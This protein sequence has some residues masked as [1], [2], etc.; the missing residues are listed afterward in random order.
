MNFTDSRFTNNATSTVLTILA[1]ILG[2][3]GGLLGCLV[4]LGLLGL[5]SPKHV[6][7]KIKP[8][9]NMSDAEAYQLICKRNKIS[10]LPTETPDELYTRLC[11]KTRKSCIIFIVIGILGIVAFYMAVV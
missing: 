3:A 2:F 4:G 9:P 8:T 7:S 10:A 11:S 5:I 6:Y 1:V